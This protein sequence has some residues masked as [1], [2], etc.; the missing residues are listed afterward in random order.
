VVCTRVSAVIVCQVSIIALN[1]AQQRMI[2]GG[3]AVTI[4]LLQELVVGRAELT[5]YELERYIGEHTEE[6][7]RETPQPEGGLHEHPAHHAVLIR[8]EPQPKVLHQHRT[9]VTEHTQPQRQVDHDVP[10][11]HLQRARD[12]RKER[13]GEERRREEGRWRRRREEER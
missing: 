13:R 3:A 12:N 1:S 2:E 5:T 6:D 9:K 10:G 7:A 4:V 8:E 11:F